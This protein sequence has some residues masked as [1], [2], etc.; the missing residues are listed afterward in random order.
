MKTLFFSVV[1]VLFAFSFTGCK[2]DFG[3]PVENVPSS[4]AGSVLVKFETTASPFLKDGGDDDE[5]D[6]M[7]DITGFVTERG[8]SVSAEVELVAMPNNAL[9]DSTT[10]NNDGGFEFYQVPPGSYNVV[11]V[12]G[13]SIAKTIK[14]NL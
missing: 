12:V 1:F 11:V 7:F 2:D 4:I 10:T 3:T 5:P 9:V 6:P 14:V 13:G 8:N